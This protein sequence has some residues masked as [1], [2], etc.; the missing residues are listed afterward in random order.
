[1][2]STRPNCLFFLQIGEE[3][4]TGCLDSLGF[5]AFIEYHFRILCDSFRSF[6]AI[7][8]SSGVIINS[9]YFESPWLNK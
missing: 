5:S 3:Q 1:M 6:K 2:D 9:S 8:I 7:G 4:N